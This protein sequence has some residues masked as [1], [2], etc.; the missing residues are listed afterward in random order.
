MKAIVSKL[1]RRGFFAAAAASPLAI[2]GVA[3]EVEKMGMGHTGLEGGY[4]SDSYPQPCAPPDEG[5]WLTQ[6][7]AALRADLTKL[8]RPNV[9]QQAVSRLDTDLVATRS[10]SLAGRVNIQRERNADRQ[11]IS[12]R[13]YIEREIESL[14]TRKLKF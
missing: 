14:L 13:D 4:A 11:Y 1:S 10:F 12:N 9:P 2:G 8:T 5:P 6:R 3:K 7:L